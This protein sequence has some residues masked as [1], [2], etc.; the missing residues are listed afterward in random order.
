MSTPEEARAVA[1]RKEI[2]GSNRWTTDRR[3]FDEVKKDILSYFDQT[4]PAVADAIRF[5]LRE[6]VPVAN[7]GNG[8]EITNVNRHHPNDLAE[9]RKD[10]GGSCYQINYPL[11]K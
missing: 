2:L 5:G 11:A 7:Y 9:Y 8:M 3:I 4:E 10:Q 6:V 1:M